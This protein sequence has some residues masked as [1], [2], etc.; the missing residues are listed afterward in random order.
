MSHPWTCVVSYHTDPEH[1]GVAKFNRQLARRLGV[2]MVKLGEHYWEGER[3]LFSMKWAELPVA[4]RS[5]CWHKRDVLWHDTPTLAAP[6]TGRHW[7]LPAIGVPALVQPSTL[8][9]PALFTFGMSHKIQVP[10]FR[11]LQAQLPPCQLWVS[12]ATHEGAGP[13]RIPDLMAAWGATARNLGTLSDEALGLVWPHVSALVAFFDAGLRA[14]NTT[15]HAALDAGVPVI[16]NHGDETPD[17]LRALT[18]DYRGLT[19]FPPQ[20]E[21]PSPYTWARLLEALCDPSR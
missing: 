7:Y 14:N 5:L 8:V 18:H 4:L 19:K 17:D 11:A 1:C 20:P 16:T 2:P 9:Q 6:V 21:G 12:T 10:L 3:P 15:V 13:S